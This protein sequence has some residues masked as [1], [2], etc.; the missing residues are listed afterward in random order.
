MTDTPKRC[1]KTDDPLFIAYHDEEWGAPIHDDRRLF[2]FLSLSGTQAGLSWTTILR[3]REN[4]RAAFANFEIDRVAAYNEDKLAELL[5]NP[6]IIRN[7]QKVRSVIN[8]AQKA[9]AIRREFGSLDTYLW[10][11]VGGKPIIH[12]WE[13]MAQI[14]ATTEEAQIMSKDLKKRGFTFVGPTICY[15]FM[16]SVGM[17]NDHLVF[18]FR[19]TEIN[20]G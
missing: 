16:E 1:W 12:Q 8:N 4:Y 19:Y 3:K 20:S 2:E 9:Q 6:G 15:A 14:P 5:Q 11:F 17:V 7:R 10:S 13:S 18:C